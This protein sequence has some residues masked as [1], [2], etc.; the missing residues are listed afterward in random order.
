MNKMLDKMRLNLKKQHSE[1]LQEKRVNKQFLKLLK[2]LKHK[3]QEMSQKLNKTK[4]ENYS[5]RS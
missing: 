4:L 5:K 1:E 3:T 2:D